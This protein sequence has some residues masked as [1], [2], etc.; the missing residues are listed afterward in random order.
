MRLRLTST[1]SEPEGSLLVGYFSC[2]SRS[3]ADRANRIVGHVFTRL[4][5]YRVRP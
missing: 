2:P 1:S 5:L 4:L 3:R